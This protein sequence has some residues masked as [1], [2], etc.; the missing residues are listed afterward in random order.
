MDRAFQFNSRR[1]KAIM[2]KELRDFRR[3]R[4]VIVTMML[5]PIIFILA[6]LI[7]IFSIKAGVL[8][9]QIQTRIGISLFYMLLIPA[10]VPTVISAYSVVGEKEQGTLEPILITPIS[11]E[12]FLIGKALAAVVPAVAVAYFVFGI[13]LLATSLFASAQIHSVIFNGP[14][15]LIQ[16]VYTPLIAGWSIWA[17]LAI[18]SRTN[19]VRVAQQLS[20]LASLPPLLIV[21]LF[22]TDVISPTIK[23]AIYFAILLLLIN[24]AGWKLVSRLFNEERLITGSTRN[25]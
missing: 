22:A 9:P 10:I 2:I 19:D 14:R 23:Y 18:S 4:F 16:F 3:N 21:V 5:L 12:E 25:G 1:I 11:R 15:L 7:S 17:C 24:L 13:F 6:P 8:S 20:T